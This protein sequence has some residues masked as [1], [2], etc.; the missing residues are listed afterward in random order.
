MPFDPPWPKA[1]DY[2]IGDPP[3]TIGSDHVITGAKPKF[4]FGEILKPQTSREQIE[5]EL[6]QKIAKEL[7]TLL[8]APDDRYADQ[9]LDWVVEIVETYGE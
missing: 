6:L 2:W 1:T 8:N 4:D 5:K 9:V 7:K 3:G